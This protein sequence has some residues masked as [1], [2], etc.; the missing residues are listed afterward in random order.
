LLLYILFIYSSKIKKLSLVSWI[1]KN[2]FDIKK[3]KIKINRLK[4]ANIRTKPA[5]DEQICLVAANLLRTKEYEK[6]IAQCDKLVDKDNFESLKTNVECLIEGNKHF[7]ALDLIQQFLSRNR[8]FKELIQN[9]SFLIKFFEIADRHQKNNELPNALELF[10]KLEQLWP[11][12]PKQKAV[13]LKIKCLSR[14]KKYDEALNCACELLKQFPNNIKLNNLVKQIELISQM[15]RGDYLPALNHFESLINQ[16]PH[17]KM[18]FVEK[19]NGF[20]HLRNFK[21]AIIFYDKVLSLFPNDLD[22]LFGKA[23][24]LFHS[25]YMNASNELYFKLI[26]MDPQNAKYCLGYGKSLMEKTRKNDHVPR[27]NLYGQHNFIDNSAIE[28]LKI[29]DYNKAIFYLEKA[30]KHFPNEQIYLNECKKVL[31][32]KM[33]RNEISTNDS[34]PKVSSNI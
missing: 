17:V 12:D 8:A 22:C 23:E 29:E 28:Q 19:A 24:C 33:P 1:C 9:E 20:F 15:D 4:I 13:I 30:I 31:R 6:A 21:E 32:N 11:H 34:F 3:S 5:T 25:N 14:M 27:V 2:W 26:E 7:K 18:N 16:F 10:K